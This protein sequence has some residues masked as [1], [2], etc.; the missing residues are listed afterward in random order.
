MDASNIIALGLGGLG[1]TIS[2]YG[3]FITPKINLKTKRLKKRLEYRFEL[4]QKML[5]LWEFANQ[6]GKEHNI[7]PLMLDINK[8]I[9]LYGYNSEIDSFKELVN[10]YN[11]CVQNQN[12]TN[13]QKLKKKFSDFFQLLLIHIEKK[14]F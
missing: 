10:F 4:F 3:L 8:L 6:P 12:E 14:L 5:E 2:I 11:Y 13:K 1:F 7:E 9:Q